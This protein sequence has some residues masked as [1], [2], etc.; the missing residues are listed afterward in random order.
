MTFIICCALLGG[1]LWRLG[2]GALTT[3]T[4]FSLGTDF[5]RAI[6]ACLGAILCWRFGRP[7]LAEI[8]AIF[9]G[10]CIAGWGPF[11][12]MGTESGIPEPSWKRWLPRTLGF[13]ENTM[14]HDFVGMAECGLICMAAPAAV[15]G[16]LAGWH[17][18]VILLVSG[19]LFA[20]AYLLARLPWPVIPRFARGQEWGEV[21]AGGIVGAAF[22]LAAS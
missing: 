16:W 10:V 9:L 3:L 17:G 21:F 5:A 12:G 13:A 20:P 6:R 11:Q 19:L 2:G 18:A 7:G 8:P 1:L 4:G 14:P 22:A 15:A